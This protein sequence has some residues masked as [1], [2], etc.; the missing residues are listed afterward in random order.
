VLDGL[1]STDEPEASPRPL[2]EGGSNECV[3][4]SRIANAP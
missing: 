4:S 3:P 1:S 2:R